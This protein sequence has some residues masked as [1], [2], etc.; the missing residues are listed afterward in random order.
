MSY[1][2]VNGHYAVRMNMIVS[3]L[4]TTIQNFIKTEYKRDTHAHMYAL[5]KEG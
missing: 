1:L 5:V 4:N 3:I 2:F